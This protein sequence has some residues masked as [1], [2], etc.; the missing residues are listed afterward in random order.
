MSST[1]RNPPPLQKKKKKNTRYKSKYKNID[2]LPNMKYRIS[3]IKP[4]PLVREDYMQRHY[5][6]YIR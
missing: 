4:L 1:A 6:D 5:S 3:S 2:V